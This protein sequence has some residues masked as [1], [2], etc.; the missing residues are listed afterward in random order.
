MPVLDVQ[1]DKVMYLKTVRLTDRQNQVTGNVIQ[2]IKLPVLLSS[3]ST[4]ILKA[5]LGEMSTN[6]QQSASYWPC[7]RCLTLHFHH[8]PHKLNP[9]L[10]SQYLS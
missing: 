3:L 4:E 7:F 9:H 1:D 5:F 10:Q 2:A 8:P 6:A